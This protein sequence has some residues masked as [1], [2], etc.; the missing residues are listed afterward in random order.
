MEIFVDGGLFEILLAVAVGYT[1]N[2]IFQ[3]KY[4]LVIFSCIAIVAP[5]ALIFL[6]SGEL[7]YW[8]I[9]I[10]VMNAVLLVVL[11]WKQRLTSPGT[12][13]LNMEKFKR[14][15]YNKPVKGDLTLPEPN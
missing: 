11:L 9:G 8:I 2:F 3:D 13:L 15:I 10:C 1:V 4:L 6:N 5:V 14:K 7:R 12:P